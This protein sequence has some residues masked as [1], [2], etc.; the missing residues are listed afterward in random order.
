MLYILWSIFL[1]LFLE[2][3]T[4]G[5]SEGKLPGSLRGGK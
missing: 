2:N 5:G 1:F 3:R 4:E